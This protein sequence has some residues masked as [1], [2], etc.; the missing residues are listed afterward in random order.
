MS[1]PGEGK[2]FIGKAN[3][4]IH[5]KGKSRMR[6]ILTLVLLAM[7]AGMPAFADMDVEA[8]KHEAAQRAAAQRADAERQRAKEQMKGDAAAKTNAAMSKHLTEAQRKALGLP[9]AGSPSPK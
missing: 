5:E 2:K 1:G 6:R 9:P 7:L 4:Y 8:E 3:V